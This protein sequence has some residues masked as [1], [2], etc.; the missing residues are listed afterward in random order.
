MFLASIRK[1]KYP[2]ILI[3]SLLLFFIFFSLTFAQETPTPTPNDQASQDKFNQLQEEIKNLQNK[4]SQ[5]QGQENTLSSQ[6]AVM[7]NQINLSQLKINSTKEEIISFNKGIEITIKKEANLKKSLDNLTKILINR[8]VATYQVASIQSFTVLFSSTNASDL[9]TRSNY[10]KII[11]AHDKQLIYETQQAKNDYANQKNIFEAKKAKVEALKKQ[12]EVYN[13]QLDSEK[14]SKKAL[15]AETQGSEANYQQLL[16]EAEEQLARFSGFVQRQG[17]ASLLDNQTQCDDW[18]CYYN[19]RDSVWGTTSLNGTQYTLA[20]DGCLVTSMA[21]VY[22]HYGHRNV[23]P[24][25]INGI[26][27][28]FASYYPAYLKY[29]ISADGASSTR[30][31]VDLD[32]VLASGHPIIVGI[33]YDGGPKPDHFVVF[34]SGSNGNYQMNDPFTPNGK[35]ISFRDRYPTEKI[36]EVDRVVF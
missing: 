13:Q 10:L 5:L 32:S 29:S 6:I 33:S 36:V 24:L 14:Q 20:S 21:M 26:P 19:Q 1:F 30:E 4:I 2:S 9:M 28:N 8:I 25:T 11:Q 3:I 17:G 15:L 31:G 7:D 35:N 27:S 12:L 18:G 16:K 23:T 34:I 22:T